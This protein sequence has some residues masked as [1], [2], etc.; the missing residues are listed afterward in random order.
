M[1]VICN[2]RSH[3]IDVPGV[4]SLDE[5]VR[6]LAAQSDDVKA[7]TAVDGLGRVTQHPSVHTDSFVDPT[8]VLI[9]GIVVCRGCY[10]APHAIVR[11]DEK[12]GFEPCILGEH[13]NIQDCAIVHAQTSRIG[14]RVIVAHQAIVHGAT[15]EDDV[16][17]Y[18]QSVAD[19]DTVLGRGCFLHQGSYVGKG[20]R[21][22]PGRYVSPGQRVLTQAE[23]DQLPEVP[24]ELKA[25]RE[26]VLA[27]NR[28]HVVSHRAL[29]G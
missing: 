1:S 25:I 13:S 28:S 27:H 7:V 22:A 4:S 20:L 9:G 2:Q 10:I 23:A 16:T 24:D 14:R 12:V 11:L 21:L 8:A 29:V 6:W 15:V 17:L 3:P 18:I 5:A 19:G 26:S